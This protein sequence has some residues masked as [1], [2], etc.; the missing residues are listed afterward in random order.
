[1][2]VCSYLKPQP[3][4]SKVVLIL[5]V[6]NPFQGVLGSIGLTDPSALQELFLHLLKPL[7]AS[8]V[9]TVAQTPQYISIYYFKEDAACPLGFAFAVSPVGSLLLYLATQLCMGDRDR[10]S[11]TLNHLWDPWHAQPL[12]PKKLRLPIL[13]TREFP[14]PRNGMDVSQPT[15]DLKES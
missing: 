11:V 15:L 12:L 5:A 13:G 3:V 14:E 6:R 9:P 1:M 10:L 7:W 2:I 8:D 4:S